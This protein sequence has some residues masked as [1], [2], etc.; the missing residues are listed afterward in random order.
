MSNHALGHCIHY[1]ADARFGIRGAT[2]GVCHAGICYRDVRLRATVYPV[3]GGLP[4][5][6]PCTAAA[7]AVPEADT[8][9]S[10]TWPTPEQVA[11]AVAETDR[12]VAA[13]EQDQCPECGA[14]MV[15]RETGGG[16]YT[17][18]CPTC[19]GVGVIACARRPR[20]GGR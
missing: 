15:R 7:R 10:R 6:L 19:P 11:E 12:A 20:R 8:C 9:P 16:G 5:S 4:V 3:G 1:G 18:R 14:A 13:F 17:A 2:E